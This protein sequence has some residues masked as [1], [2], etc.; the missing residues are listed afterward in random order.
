[1]LKGIILIILYAITLNFDYWLENVLSFL[2][3]QLKQATILNFIKII[4]DT[5]KL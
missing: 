3:K 4:I 1:M 5:V 2:Y